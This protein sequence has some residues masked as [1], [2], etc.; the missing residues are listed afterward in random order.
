MGWAGFI[1]LGF[2]PPRGAG[3]FSRYYIRKAPAR[4]PHTPETN[5]ATKTNRATRIP[6]PMRLVNLLSRR[7]SAKPD[8]MLRRSRF[9]SS[10][11]FFSSMLKSARVETLLSISWNCVRLTYLAS[12]FS[13]DAATALATAFVGVRFGGLE[14]F[15]EAGFGFGDDRFGGGARLVLA[16]A[17]GE[18][19]FVD[20]YGGGGHMVGFGVGGKT[21][22]YRTF[23]PPSQFFSVVPLV[24]SK[25]RLGTTR[26]DF[27]LPPSVPRFHGIGIFLAM[28]AGRFSAVVISKKFIRAAL[29]ATAG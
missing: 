10:L 12:A 1:G 14:V 19:Q 23:P 7:S 25:R 8:S 9:T 22:L 13:S 2:F 5:L 15:S 4:R 29:S 26:I 11:M 28:A 21:E 18:E 6:S 20:G 3:G 27:C 24:V 17:L 16:H